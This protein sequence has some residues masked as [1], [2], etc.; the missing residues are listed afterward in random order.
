ML[1]TAIQ[2]PAPETFPV[3]NGTGGYDQMSQTEQY[4]LLVNF[5]EQ[6]LNEMFNELFA[7]LSVAERGRLTEETTKAGFHDA[8]CRRDY[9]LTRLLK[10]AEERGVPYTQILQE[11]HGAQSAVGVLLN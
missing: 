4:K 10:V 8:A 9:M 7:V 5:S 6:D 2:A 11:I 1:R 3:A